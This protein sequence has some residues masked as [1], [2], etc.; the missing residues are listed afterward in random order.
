MCVSTQNTLGTFNNVIIL[1]NSVSMNELL[2]FPPSASLSN[3][4]QFGMEGRMGNLV[5]MES[6]GISSLRI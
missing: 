6:I 2:L 5:V 4:A 1:L 3:H